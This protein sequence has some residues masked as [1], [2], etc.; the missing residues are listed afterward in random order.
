M[1]LHLLTYSTV[2][3]VNCRFFHWLQYLLKLPTMLLHWHDGH[4]HVRLHVRICAGACVDV[5]V[6]VV[7]AGIVVVVSNN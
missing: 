5:G 4:V 7:G 3:T 1:S 6:D 2:F